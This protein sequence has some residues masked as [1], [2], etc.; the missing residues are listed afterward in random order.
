MSHTVFRSRRVVTPEGVRPATV[1]VRGEKIEAVAD[2]DAWPA[3]AERVDVG[4]KVLMPAVVDTHVHVNEPGRTDWEGFRTATRAAASGGVASL[5]DMPLNS[6]PPTTS[7]EA[8]RAKKNEALGQCLIDVGFWGGVVPGNVTDL[9]GLARE[10]A[11]GCKAFM[12]FSGVDEFPGCTEADLRPAMLELK[13][14]G[15]PLLVHAEVEGP[16]DAVAEQIAKMNPRAY[17]TYLA[18]RPQAAEGQAVQLISTLC[19]E[20]RA[21]TH[22]VHHSAADVLPLIRSLRTEGLPFTAE[23][24]PHYLHFTAE[25]VPDGATAFKC[26]PPVREEANREQLWKALGEG[27]LELVASDH[28]PCT[29]QLKKQEA[30]DFMAAW[31]GISGL[32]LGLPVTWTGAAARGY[33]I[34]QLVKWMC[35]APARLAGLSDRKGKLAAGFD[36]DLTVFDPEAE[37]VVDVQ[38]IQH[39]NKLTPYAGAAL[40]GVVLSTYVRGM[41]VFYEGEHASDLKGQFL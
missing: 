33:S 9:E 17:S 14:L 12:C 38:K 37:F 27:L 19:R 24:C 22:V 15:I 7:A 4:D 36:A 23:T 29:P 11:R 21:R 39:K 16:I 10:G 32:Q 5:V 34:H 20:T 6:I 13:R 8:L 28:S 41:C 18:S 35:E 31:G 26:A 25:K 1:H 3:S 40:L 30:G 2:Y